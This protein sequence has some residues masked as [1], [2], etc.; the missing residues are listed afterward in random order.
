MGKSVLDTQSMTVASILQ[1]KT[2]I[3][4]LVAQCGNSIC[5]LNDESSCLILSNINNLPPC[6]TFKEKTKK[7]DVFGRINQCP[8]NY[9][10]PVLGGE[11]YV[12]NYFFINSWDMLIRLPYFANEE[13]MGQK[14]K[15]TVEAH[16]LWLLD[17]CSST[18][19]RLVD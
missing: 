6:P 8:H 12:W 3:L 13:T 15:I 16:V 1:S 11:V 17:Q 14:S 19:P 9:S 2:F 4:F 5:H 18:V 10:I 7:I